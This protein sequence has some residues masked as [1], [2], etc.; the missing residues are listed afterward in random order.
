MKVTMLPL[1]ALAVAAAPAMAQ[2]PAA[3]S[4]QKTL[5]A[6]IGVYVFPSKGQDASQQSK[7]EAECYSW[8][9]QN[10]GSDPFSLAKQSEAAQ[11][12][13]AQAKQQAAQA[14]AGAGVKG[15]VG[16]GRGRGAHR[17]DRQRRRRRGGGVRRGGGSCGRQTPGQAGREAGRRPGRPARGAD[18]GGNRRGDRELQ[19]G[20]QRLPRGEE[21]HGEVLT[22]PDQPPAIAPTTR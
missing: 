4:G 19:E 3:P 2:A 11:Q 6:T 17:R 15:A 13:A 22:G 20:L 16:G 9:T 1:L 12:Q 5:A 8:A 7:D 18:P 14:G 10:T 21:L